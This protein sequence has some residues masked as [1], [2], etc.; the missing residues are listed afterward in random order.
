MSVKSIL[1]AMG[2]GIVIGAIA[3]MM[4]DPIND[5]T[6]KKIHKCAN[7]VFRTIGTIVDDIVSY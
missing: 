6:H 3:G 7:N 1:G 4:I 2:T 5:K